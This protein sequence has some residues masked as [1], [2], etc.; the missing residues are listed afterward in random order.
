MIIGVLENAT[1]IIYT[2]FSGEEKTVTS[3]LV[4]NLA[5][6]DLLVFLTFKFHP[7][8]IVEF[9]QIIWKIDNDQDFFLLVQPCNSDH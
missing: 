4:G 8:W 7:V 5:L 2:I 1:V 6:A 3:Y 9:I